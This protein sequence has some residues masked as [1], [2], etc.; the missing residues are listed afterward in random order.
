VT[1]YEAGIAVSR[2][3]KK[4]RLTRAGVYFVL[5]REG[6]TPDRH[7]PVSDQDQETICTLWEKYRNQARIVN[8]TGFSK[9][10]VSRLVQRCPS[11]KRSRR[12]RF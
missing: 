10:K 11:Y 4:Y 6:H 5:K 3:M 7:L 1:D 9:Q 2:L 12:K 8:E